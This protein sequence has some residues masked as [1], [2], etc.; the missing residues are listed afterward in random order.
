MAVEAAA[1][2][3]PGIFSDH[4]DSRGTVP[5][6][7]SVTD[8]INEGQVTFGVPQGPFGVAKVGGQ[9]GV[10]GRFQ[11]L[12]ELVRHHHLHPGAW[13]T[14]GIIAV[15]RAWRIQAKNPFDRCRGLD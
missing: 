4:A 3:F 1:V 10:R 5:A 14:G 2:A 8:Q 9:Q 7:Q 11:Y 13:S 6:L 15:S 12:G